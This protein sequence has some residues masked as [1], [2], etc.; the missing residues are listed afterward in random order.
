MIDPEFLKFAAN[1]N[2]ALGGKVDNTD[3]KITVN[4]MNSNAR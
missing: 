1:M 2:E 3:T 4:I